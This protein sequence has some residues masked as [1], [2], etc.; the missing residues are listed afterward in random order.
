VNESDTNRLYFI[1]ATDEKRMTEKFRQFNREDITQRM[2]KTLESIDPDSK[3]TGKAIMLKMKKYTIAASFVLIAGSIIYYAARGF[4]K[5]DI[6]KTPTTI[7]T[8]TNDVQPGTEKAVLTLADGATIILDDSKKGII[9]EQNGITVTNQGSQLKYDASRSKVLNQPLSYYT[10]STVRGGQYQLLLADG[11]KVFLNAA[12]SIRFPTAFTGNER[13]IEITGEA[14]FEVAKDAQKP[15]KVKVKGIEVEVLGTHFNINAYDDESV[16]KTTLLEGKVKVA[17]LSADKLK[18]INQKIITP[19][20]AASITSAGTIGVTE[21]DID[22]AVSWKNNS[23]YFQ[24]DDIETISRQLSR[25]YDVDIVVEG[26][27][28]KKYTGIISRNVMVSEI[29]TFLE[30]SGGVEAVIEG[31]KIIIRSHENPKSK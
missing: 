21:T 14:Y 28:G 6:A 2:D 1:Q 22:Q 19:G 26:K 15:F 29:L 5:K 3:S 9:N 16:I 12:S 10:L 30:M 18:V 8:N 27:V 23:F 20:Q 31:R 24:D 17:T 7:K 13:N 4:N 11:S 25:W